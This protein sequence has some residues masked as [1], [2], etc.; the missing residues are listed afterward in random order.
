MVFPFRLHKRSPYVRFSRTLIYGPIKQSRHITI[1]PLQREVPFSTRVLCMVL[2]DNVIGE[3]RLACSNVT[4]VATISKPDLCDAL[5]L[6]IEDSPDYV[7]TVNIYPIGLPMA[8]HPMV[9]RPRFDE[10]FS[11]PSPG[12]PV[13]YI[14]T[15]SEIAEADLSRRTLKRPRPACSSNRAPPLVKVPTTIWVTWRG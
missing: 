14:K 7:P 1:G 3:V 11:H 2:K 13:P 5:V 4:D 10:G 6:G 9:W 12:T 8:K 15:S